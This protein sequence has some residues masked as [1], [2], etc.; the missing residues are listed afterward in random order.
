MPVSRTFAH[1]HRHPRIWITR[2]GIALQ[3]PAQRT[4]HIFSEAFHAPGAPLPHNS[5][6][7]R[8]GGAQWHI[9]CA[10]SETARA[11]PQATRNRDNG[12]ISRTSRSTRSHCRTLVR[13]ARTART[14]KKPPALA[15]AARPMLLPSDPASRSGTKPDIP[16]GRA[17]TKLSTLVSYRRRRASQ[18]FHARHLRFESSA[19]CCR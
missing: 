13:Q 8:I 11:P 4:N 18:L 5:E 14:K 2:I 6:L 1:R 7:S 3:P 17:V 10:G 9:P 12:S 19:A 16:P 15:C